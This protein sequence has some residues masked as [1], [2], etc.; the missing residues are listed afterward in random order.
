VT[1][2]EVVRAEAA[3]TVPLIVRAA[4]PFDAFRIRTVV[5]APVI[6]TVLVPAVN[7]EPVPEVSQLPVT[8]QAPVVSV[9]IPD[10]PPVIVKFDTL[11]A[12]AF[13]VSTPPLPIVRAPPVR[14]RLPVARV[15]AP[16]PP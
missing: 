8:V 5:T 6:V 9:S 16:A 10:A 7:V 2:P 1:S 14:P 13:A 11:T 15:V 12:E 4:N 3:E